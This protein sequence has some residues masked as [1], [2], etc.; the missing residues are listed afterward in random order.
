MYLDGQL[1]SLVLYTRSYSYNCTIF[2][3][4]RVCST[5]QLYIVFRPEASAPF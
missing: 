4:L 5:H 3:I 2:V 1:R